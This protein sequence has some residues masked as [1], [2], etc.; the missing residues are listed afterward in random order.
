MGWRLGKNYRLDIS[1]GA[2]IGGSITIEDKENNELG[3]TDYD[4]APFVGFTLRGQF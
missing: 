3:E 2:V 1:G 4:A